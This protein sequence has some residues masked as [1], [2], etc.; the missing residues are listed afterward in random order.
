MN[1]KSETFVNKLLVATFAGALALAGALLMYF[2]PIER[3]L[4][5]DRGSGECIIESQF[6]LKGAEGQ[7]WLLDETQGMHIDVHW[8]SEKQQDSYRAV[9]HLH[10]GEEIPVQKSFS[11]NLS[12]KEHLKERFNQFLSNTDID[13]FEERQRFTRAVK[14]GGIMMIFAL[15]WLLWLCFPRAKR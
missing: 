6:L 9:I 10:S 5:C 1:T 7:D 15:P 4:Y 8:N 11:S 12:N 14:L 3:A 2:T 13:D